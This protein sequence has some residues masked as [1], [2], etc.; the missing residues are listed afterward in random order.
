MSRR[1]VV[2]AKAKG[3]MDRAG[4][5]YDRQVAGLGRELIAELRG[6]LERVRDHPEWFAVV[7]RGSRHAR[8]KRFPYAVYYLTTPT[9]VTVVAFLH[10][11]QSRDEKLRG[12]L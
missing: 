4:K 9:A 12:R 11:R 1:L 5:W 10:D 2:R 7:H 6:V 3:E 8:L